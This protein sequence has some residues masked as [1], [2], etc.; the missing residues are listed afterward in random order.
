[1]IH[2]YKRKGKGERFW[3]CEDGGGFPYG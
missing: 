3:C 1:L 2:F